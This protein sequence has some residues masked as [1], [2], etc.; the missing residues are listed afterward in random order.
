MIL[1]GS[2]TY[3]NETLLPGTLSIYF[4][5]NFLQSF[6]TNG[7]FSFEYTPDASYLDVGEHTIEIMQNFVYKDEE[8]NN[9]YNK[10]IIL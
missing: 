10:K 3:D 9:F 1:S 6:T 7:T 2:L 4:D 8:I 5:G